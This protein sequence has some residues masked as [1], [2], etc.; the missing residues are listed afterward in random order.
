MAYQNYRNGKED[1]I[2]FRVA[3][4]E[5]PE[6]I[7]EAPRCTYE[8]AQKMGPEGYAGTKY[9]TDGSEN[10]Q[11]NLYGETVSV[12]PTDARAANTNKSVKR[13]VE[14]KEPYT[15]A[16]SMETIHRALS[17]KVA[18]GRPLK[19]KTPEELRDA[20]EDYFRSLM[21]VMVDDEGNEGD[22]VWRR[23]PTASGLALYLGLTREGLF[24]TYSK[25]DQYSEIL[26]T[27]IGVIESFTEEYALES[28]YPTGAIFVLKN[29]YGWSDKR[30]VSVM[31]ESGR[32]QLTDEQ[33]AAMLPDPDTMP[34]IIDVDPDEMTDA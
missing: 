34:D 11:I 20:C 5:P 15:P 29:G 25:R 23:K 10:A 28:K 9:I 27:A 21:G 4:L 14:S 24:D 18:A 31:R 6:D 2:R 17:N 1:K 8:E 30:E 12:Q 16:P 33:I 13:I 3:P 26:K 7:P 32:Q 19:F 22:I